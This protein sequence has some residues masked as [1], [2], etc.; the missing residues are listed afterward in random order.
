M[1]GLISKQSL[2]VSKNIIINPV[3]LART[4]T[5]DLKIKW[6][7]PERIPRWKPLR[8]GDVGAYVPP[9]PTNIC[10]QYQYS[11]ELEK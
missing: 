3:I 9:D 5:V 11:T 4:R 2:N 10:V 6:E 8:T 1:F 7:R